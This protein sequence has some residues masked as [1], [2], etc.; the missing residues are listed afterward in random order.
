MSIFSACIER[1]VCGTVVRYSLYVDLTF[2]NTMLKRFLMKKMLK[3]QLKGV[4][5]DQQEKLITMI[6]KNPDLFKKIAD[7]IQK[8]M[9]NENK[10]QMA[11]TM[12]VMKK[13]QNELREL[14]QE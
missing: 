5:E 13:Y 7:E 12:E 10:E 14:M 9:K 6:E 4:P 8:K 1:K 11:A 3:S 2:Q